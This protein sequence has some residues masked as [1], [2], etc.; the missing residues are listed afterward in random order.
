M[1][2]KIYSLIHKVVGKRI[3]KDKQYNRDIVNEICLL[4][5]ENDISFQSEDTI[6]CLEKLLNTYFPF[7]E[8][9]KEIIFESMPTYDARIVYSFHTVIRKYQEDIKMTDGRGRIK[10]VRQIPV[11]LDVKKLKRKEKKV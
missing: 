5:L 10:E 2:Q 3:K 4:L 11:G 7:I 1:E 8:E 9:G 6:K